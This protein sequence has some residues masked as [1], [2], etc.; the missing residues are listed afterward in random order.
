M[1]SRLARASWMFCAAL[2]LVMLSCGGSARAQ[3]VASSLDR[4][5]REIALDVARRLPDSRDRCVELREFT[6][7]GPRQTPASGG[8]GIVKSLMDQLNRLD[9]RVD[10]S[11]KVFVQG[12]YDLVKD[13]ASELP[14]LRIDYQVQTGEGK[15]IASPPRGV[16]GDDSIASTV[17]LTVALPPDEDPKQRGQRILEAYTKPSFFLSHKTRVATDARSPY[18][19]EILVDDEPRAVAN[20]EG[21]AFASIA[22][23]ETYMVRLYNDSDYDA[24]VVLKIDGLSVFTFSDLKD[25]ATGSPKFDYVIVPKK[26]SGTVRGWHRTNDRSYSFKVSEYAQSAAAELKQKSDLG[27]ITAIFSAAWPKDAPIPPDEP[28][29]QPTRLAS[30]GVNATARGPEISATHKEVERTCGRTRAPITVRYS[31]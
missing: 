30:R 22:K 31:K 25:S 13:S 8:P 5:C 17:G 2:G 1:I 7:M 4:E 20:H 11:A 18:A 27:M 15:L 23:D 10:E 6:F 19:V 14:A 3:A 29:D 26:S 28:I 16:F 9:I 12:Q 21:Q 24:A